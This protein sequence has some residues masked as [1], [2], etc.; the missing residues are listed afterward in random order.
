[1]AHCANVLLRPWVPFLSLSMPPGLLGMLTGCVTAIAGA[2]A[3]ISFVCGGSQI[4]TDR[5]SLFP[6]LALS[7][8]L[9]IVRFHSIQLHQ[10]SWALFQGSEGWAQHRAVGRRRKD[11]VGSPP[12]VRRSRDEGIEKEQCANKGQRSWKFRDDFLEEEGI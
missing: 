6:C 10:Q 2:T 3:S 4:M 5:N 1:M 11:T 7:F 8:L 9:I 12:G